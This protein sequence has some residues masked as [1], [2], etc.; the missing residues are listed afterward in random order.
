[1]TFTGIAGQ[2]CPLVTGTDTFVLNSY[3]SLKTAYDAASI[4]PG[5]KLETPTGMVINEK[6]IPDLLAFKEPGKK[7][8]LFVTDGEPDRCDDGDPVCARDDVVG[9]VQSAYNQSIGTFVFG[10]QANAAL[11][12][13]LQD[14]ANAGAGQPVLSPGDAL[15][16]SCLGGDETK[17]KGKYA[18]AGGTTKFF[19]PDATDA[20]ALENALS[21]AVAGAQ[22]CTFDLQGKIEVDLAHAD[23]GHVLI[24]GAAVPYNAQNG[25]Q[26]TSPTQL[27]LVGDACA[28]LKN[29]TKGSPSIS[30]ATSS[31]PS[32]TGPAGR[33]EPGPRIRPHEFDSA[34][35][36][37]KDPFMR[38]IGR[39]IWITLALLLVATVA[40]A[41]LLTTSSSCSPPRRAPLPGQARRG[42]RPPDRDGA[43]QI[44]ARQRRRRAGFLALRD[45]QVPP[46]RPLPPDEPQL[47][48][49]AARRQLH[50]VLRAL[51]EDLR[52]R[53]QGRSPRR[54]GVRHPQRQGARLRAEGAFS[55]VGRSRLGPDRGPLRRPERG[56]APALCRPDAP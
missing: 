52:A 20:T 28:Q 16:Y 13:H 22:S 32:N 36:H 27:E 55:R 1:M 6:V 12:Q 21:A 51:R 34:A 17:A 48:D 42:L 56:G 10:L 23:L 24:D 33:A 5:A 46:L 45:G 4:K 43:R 53:R 31:S 44:K 19:T 49:H 50:R 40:T 3:A 38:G 54:Q 18:A 9:A 47:H 30:P 39:F 7:Y 11:G 29:A 26:M 2:Q 14:L 25:W 35:P 15:K 37:R 41:A 8:I